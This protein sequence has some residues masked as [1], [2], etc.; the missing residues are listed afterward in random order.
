MTNVTAKGLLIHR[1]WGTYS[2]GIALEFA[3]P[4]H[5][6]D[7]L[8]TLGAPWKVGNNSSAMLVA[9]VESEALG[10]I[11]E[12]FKG[13]GLTITPCGFH[14]CAHQ[15]KD[16]EIDNVNHSVDRGA[17]FEVTIPTEPTEQ[18]VLFHMTNKLYRVAVLQS[19]TDMPPKA[20]WADSG[21]GE[22]SLDRA[23]EVLAAGKR[24]GLRCQIVEAD[25]DIFKAA[26]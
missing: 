10:V 17:H 18:G 25:A 20:Y 1:F 9:F 12:Q 21:C 7:A 4:D 2:A 13:W 15:C 5:A 19:S 16:S 11:K 14:H 23:R 3:T 6:Q 26:L 22:L 8:R 24:D